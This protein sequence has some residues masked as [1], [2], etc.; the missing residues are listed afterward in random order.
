MIKWNNYDGTNIEIDSAVVKGETPK[1]DS[2]T[3]YRLN[4]DSNYYVFNGWDKEVVP[5]KKNETYTATYKSYPLTNV[6]ESPDGYIDTM[7]TVNGEGNIFHAFCWSFKDIEDRLPDIVNAG[8]QSVQTMPV[9]TPKSG[10]SAWWAFYQPLSFSIAEESK[11]GTKAEFLSMCAAADALGVNIIVDVVFNHMANIKDGDL[12]P[13]TTPKVFPGVADYEP[14]IYAHRNDDSNPT[15]HHNPNAEGSGAITQKY[16]YG[17]LPDLNTANSLVQDRCYSFLKECI[18]AGVD[19]FRFDA[20]KHIETPEDPEYASDFWPNTLG[21]ARTY[22]KSLTGKDL[23]AYGEVLDGPGG[24][25]DLSMY[26][27]LMAVTD[28]AYGALVKNSLLGN[29]TNAASDY[30]K[31]TDPKNLITWVESHD[32]YTSEDSHYISEKILQGYAITGTRPGS[33]SLYLSRPDDALSVGVVS[34][35]DYE[36]NTL[37]AI[38]RFHNRFYNATENVKADATLYINQLENSNGDVGAVIVDLDRTKNSYVYLDK[39]GTG[40]YYD[41]A[42]GEQ[43]VVRDGHAIIEM[44]LSGILL[45]TKSKN[46]VRPTLSIDNRGGLF[47]DNL[48]VT[49]RASHGT[50]YYSINGAAPVSFEGKLVLENLQNYQDGEGKVALDV[51]V[52]NSQF[53]ITRHFH[54]QKV[55]L[56]PGYFNV[57]NVNPD[58]YTNY[59]LYMWSWTSTQGTWSKDYTIQDG[60]VLVD[61]DHMSG[62]VGFV[63]AVFAKDYVV[64]NIH[65]WDHNA[66]KQTIDI[67]DNLLAQGYFDASNF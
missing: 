47:L 1:F 64:S 62:L 53:S 17:D 11:L 66:L 31:Q 34:S 9:Q 55:Q 14:E 24:G 15:F 22:Y 7:P 29:A 18:D 39:L 40:V 2:K 52:S 30:L 8:F 51:T 46:E 60:I 57:V 59:E 19:G 49:L 10:G 45:L 4:D 3:P 67:K 27:K 32:T 48:E 26:T 65:E 61:T 23:F 44:P 5:A 35:Y 12:E 58:Y 56:I 13:D 6:E 33:R 16:Q 50:G 41:Q 38:N 63:L 37:G 43:T 28:N 20:A 42:T 36:D 54:Y 25:R 21:K